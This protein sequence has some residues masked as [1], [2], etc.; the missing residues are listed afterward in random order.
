MGDIIEPSSRIRT[1]GDRCFAVCA[2]RLWN[3]LPLALRR[4][5]F[6]DIFKNVL[7]TVLYKISLLANVCEFFSFIYCKAPRTIFGVVRY[8]KTLLLL[9]LL[10]LSLFPYG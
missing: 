1:Y 5:S 7:K 8:S 9:L 2:P 3:S 4:S 6:I 10:L